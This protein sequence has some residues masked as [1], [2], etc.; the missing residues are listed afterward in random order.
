M[1]VWQQNLRKVNEWLHQPAGQ[2]FL[3]LQNKV[4]IQHLHAFK[5]ITEKKCL[6]IYNGQHYA[7][8]NFGYQQVIKIAPYYDYNADVA[9]EPSALPF[10]ENAIDVIILPYVL[11]C[12]LSLQKIILECYRVLKPQGVL[13]VCEFNPHSILRYQWPES[14]KYSTLSVKQLQRKL[15]LQGFDLLNQQKFSFSSLCA[16]SNLLEK[17]GCYLW[18]GLGNGFILNM[19]KRVESLTPLAKKPHW[20]SEPL[21]I[22]NTRLANV[23]TECKL[24]D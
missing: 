15:F 17:L 24:L 18:P 5:A 20:R 6:A 2:R 1:Q 7:G 14:K 8:I 21:S 11:G 12:G 13:V 22:K 3:E 19:Q 16:K 4:L 23:A 9:A 10:S